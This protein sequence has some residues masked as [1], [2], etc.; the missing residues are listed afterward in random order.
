MVLTSNYAN[1]SILILDSM[2]ATRSALRILVGQ[3]GFERIVTCANVKDALEQ[4]HKQSV[5]II[6]SDYYLG[7]GAGF[8]VVLTVARAGKSLVKIVRYPSFIAANCDTSVM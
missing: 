7:E 2:P 3:L 1:K 4:F 8:L 5:D 6:L